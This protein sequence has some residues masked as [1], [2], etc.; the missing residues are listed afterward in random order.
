MLE[1]ISDL[2]VCIY[3][4]TEYPALLGLCEKTMAG[5]WPD[6]RFVSFPTA[7]MCIR[8]NPVVHFRQASYKN[9]GIC[10]VGEGVT[11]GRFR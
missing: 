4:Y 1:N 6:D 8:L 10:R 2:C 9:I 11:A 7:L 3:V 5:L